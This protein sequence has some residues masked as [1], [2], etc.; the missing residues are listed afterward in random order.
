[1]TDFEFLGALSLQDNHSTTD[2]K[3][4]I[5]PSAPSA[6]ML[7]KQQCQVLCCQGKTKNN[8]ESF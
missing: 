3:V 7:M 1:M 6:V 4:D 2:N 8:S 5:R